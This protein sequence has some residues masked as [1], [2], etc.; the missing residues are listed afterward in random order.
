M[1]RMHLDPKVKIYWLVPSI[2]FLA[3]VWL[4]AVAGVAL[5]DEDQ[6]VFGMRPP[7]FAL[8][9]AL[10]LAVFVLLPLY[11]YYSLEYNAYSYEFSEQAIVVRNG[12]L[13]TNEVVIPYAHISRIEAERSVLE[14]LMG[15]VSVEI[16]TPGPK[17]LEINHTIP[18]IP[19][20]VNFAEELEKWKENARALRA[21]WEQEKPSQDREVLLKLLAEMRD[22]N[23]NVSGLLREIRAPP[24]KK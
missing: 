24:R 6:L 5:I 4:I 13:S 21:P 22:L 12:I 2:L 11:L 7:M 1:A 18:G 14:R 15:L 20:K 23:E 3:L 17:E 9:S 19:A 10:A 8:I 16:V